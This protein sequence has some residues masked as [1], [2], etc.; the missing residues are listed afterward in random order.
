[1][2]GVLKQSGSDYTVGEYVKDLCD[3]MIKRV[4]DIAPFKRRVIDMHE[5]IEGKAKQDKEEHSR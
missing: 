3:T 1:M 5:I 4:R 2:R